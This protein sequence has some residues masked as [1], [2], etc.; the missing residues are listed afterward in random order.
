MKKG[1][2]VKMQRERGKRRWNIYYCHFRAINSRWCGGGWWWVASD[3]G[4]KYV[5]FYPPT[6]HQRSFPGRVAFPVFFF[7]AL[8]GLLN[9]K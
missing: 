6:R 9:V 2:L 7:V 1:Y 5:A 8:L 4:Q 3:E